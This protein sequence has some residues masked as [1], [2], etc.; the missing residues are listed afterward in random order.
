MVGRGHWLHSWRPGTPLATVER[1][2]GQLMGHSTRDIG[3][4]YGAHQNLAEAREALER[5][6]AALGDVDP[7]IYSEAEQLKD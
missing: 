7:G 3:D 5:A 6:L 4:R 2:A 1:E